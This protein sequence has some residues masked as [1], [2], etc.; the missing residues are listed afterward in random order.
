M[1]NNALGASAKSKKVRNV[2]G[3]GGRGLQKNVHMTFP[4]D[5]IDL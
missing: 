3:W 4:V 2:K 5:K 1:I